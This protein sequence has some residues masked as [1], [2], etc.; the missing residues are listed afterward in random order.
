MFRFLK[1]NRQC[2]GLQSGDL[3][4][5]SQAACDDVY[6][7]KCFE[8]AEDQQSKFATILLLLFY[9]CAEVLVKKIEQDRELLGVLCR[10]VSRC[11]DVRVIRVLSIFDE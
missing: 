6:V 5:V 7:Q 10:N 3:S 4:M 8:S 9:R 2:G 1:R 11:I